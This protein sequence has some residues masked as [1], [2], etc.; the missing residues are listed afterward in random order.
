M[1]PD[2][3]L[4][5]TVIPSSRENINPPRVIQRTYRFIVSSLFVLGFAPIGAERQPSVTVFVK[6]LKLRAVETG[7]LRGFGHNSRSSEGAAPRKKAGD[8]GA[9]GSERPG[10]RAADHACS[11]LA[12]YVSGP[13]PRDE[14]EQDVA[15]D[16]RAIICALPGA[17][18]RRIFSPVDAREYTTLGEAVKRVE[19]RWG[20]LCHFDSDVPTALDLLVPFL[21]LRED[22]RCRASDGCHSS[23]STYSHPDQQLPTVDTIRHTST[24]L[25]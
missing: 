6:M 4:R 8:G 20:R 7:P 12:G 23:D 18:R 9:F 2:R 16:N 11:K 10:Q 5:R 3:P 19:S 15:K 21:F 1:I 25:T 22:R 17:K 24:S 13:N 14:V